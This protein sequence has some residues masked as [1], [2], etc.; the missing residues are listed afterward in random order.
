MPLVGTSLWMSWLTAFT[1]LSFLIAF[2]MTEIS[3][4]CSTAHPRR[5]Y[6][7]QDGRTLTQRYQK[8]AVLWIFKLLSMWLY[9]CLEA[10]EKLFSQNQMIYKAAVSP[11]R[12]FSGLAKKQRC[13]GSSRHWVLFN[14]QKKPLLK[15]GLE[16]PVQPTSGSTLCSEPS[17]WY[18]FLWLNTMSDG[19]KMRLLKTTVWPF[20]RCG[21]LN[22]YSLH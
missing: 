5:I 21:S 22:V 7:G 11:S 17:H 16:W 2:H 18:S 3:L 1:G 15:I 10:A 19:R 9:V 8:D 12:A 20:L 14:S 13:F 4:K 6:W